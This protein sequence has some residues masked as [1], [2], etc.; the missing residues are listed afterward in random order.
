ML[1]AVEMKNQMSQRFFK[2]LGDKERITLFNI[3]QI[4]S[5][6][7]REFLFRKGSPDR[8]IYYVLNGSFRVQYGNGDPGFR[9]KVGDWIGEIILSAPG[10]RICSAV[11]E[12]ASKVLIFD[13]S[14]FRALGRD[15]QISVLTRLHDLA[16]ARMDTL[17][18]QKESAQHQGTALT[19]YVRNNFRK[20]VEKYEQ[21]EI[22]LNIIKNIPRLPLYITQL[23]ELLASEMASAK[24]VADLA[25]QDPSLVCD[26]LKTVNSSRYGL[27]R[28]ISDISYAVTYLG[29]NEVYQIAVSRGLITS[30]PDSEEFRN[31]HRHS[32]LLSYVA[33][34]LGQIYDKNRASLLS[35]IALLHDVGESVLLLLAKQNPK[36][37]LFVEMLDPAKV[38]SMLLRKWNIPQQVCQ[39]IEYQAYPLFCPPTEIPTE[40]KVNIS[41]LYIAHV[42]CN[43][44]K[45]RHFEPLNDPFLDEY[46]Y[47]LNLHP[48]RIDQIAR[49]HIFKGL[50]AKAPRLPDFVRKQLSLT[51]AGD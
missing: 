4:R 42:A 14:A 12:E 48:Q 32:L 27:Q 16:L 3:G 13:Q 28:E 17:G 7:A 46:L 50:K 34:E 20:P 30:M 39:T 6:A 25:K 10:G 41:L 35:T 1:Q 44:L 15:I 45:T 49:D 19:R 47:F 31:I 36:W 9:F 22:I 33:F 21:S 8:T 26:I 18:R 2:E 24:D 23:I 29:F 43:Y 37:S 5:V 40:Q 51:G 38:G 11:A